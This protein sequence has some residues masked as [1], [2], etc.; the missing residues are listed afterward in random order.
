MERLFMRRGGENLRASP[1]PPNHSRQEVESGGRIF[2]S[3]LFGIAHSLSLIRP[4]F[5]NSTSPL[6][7]F[8]M[9]LTVKVASLLS[10]KINITDE[11]PSPWANGCQPSFAS[12]SS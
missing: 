4:Y 8:E 11:C 2:L 10:A 6:S 5:T 12:S 1:D 3:P 7:P 9:M